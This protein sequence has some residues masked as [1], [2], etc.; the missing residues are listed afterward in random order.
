MTDDFDAMADRMERAVRAEME[1]LLADGGRTAV[2]A[3]LTLALAPAWAKAMAAETQRAEGRASD[4]VEA[5]ANVI[6]NLMGSTCETLLRGDP[7]MT[8]QWICLVE[9]FFRQGRKE[10][11]IIEFHIPPAGHA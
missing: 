5:A 11:V 1:P 10:N 2:F 7:E 6:A 9:A 8:E 3:R 4:L